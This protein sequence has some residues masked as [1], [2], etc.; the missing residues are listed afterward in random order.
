[1]CI[2]DRAYPVQALRTMVRITLRT[3]ADIDYM[4]RFKLA[5]VE[6]RMNITNAI[7]HATCTTAHDIEMCIRDSWYPDCLA[8]FDGFR[9]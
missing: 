9:W 1:M 7:S 5:L 3:E 8:E 6:D 2:R 4:K